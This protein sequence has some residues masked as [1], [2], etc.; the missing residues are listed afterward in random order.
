[1]YYY[2]KWYCLMPFFLAFWIDERAVIGSGLAFLFIISQHNNLSTWD[3]WK[4]MAY[5]SW[6][7][8]AAYVAYL[9]IRKYLE[10]TFALTVP[11]GT[12][13]DSGVGLIFQQARTLPLATFL[14]YEGIWLIFLLGSAIIWYF[15]SRLLL[16]MYL[17]IFVIVM[18]V[19]YSVWDVT[20][21]L[22]YGFP[23]ML[24]C[25]K[26]AFQAFSKRQIL[27]VLLVV[28]SL[29][30]FIPSYKNHYFLFY[31]QVPLPAKAV[32]YLKGQLPLGE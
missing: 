9:A 15:H 27:L 10:V 29:N 12:E 13:Y 5:K 30:L 18:A 4:K 1:M 19:S 25:A 22:M 16:A 17:L 23:I 6:P 32:Y 31:W 20:R 2:Q 26:Y 28:L 11:I 7:F 8:L 3:D 14:S 24:V 21:S